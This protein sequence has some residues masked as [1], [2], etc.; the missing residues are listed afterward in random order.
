[1]RKKEKN[2]GKDRL[3]LKPCS[4]SFLKPP[5][6]GWTKTREIYSLIV[7]N[8]EMQKQGAVRATLF[9]EAL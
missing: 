9:L 2:K 3:F 8:T 1:M 5:Q 6:T 4:I 7:W